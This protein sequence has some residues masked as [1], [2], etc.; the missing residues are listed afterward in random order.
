MSKQTKYHSIF[1][2]IR[3]N[4]EHHFQR[5]RSHPRGLLPETK[6]WIY[7]TTPLKIGLWLEGILF[8]RQNRPQNPKVKS[9]THLGNPHIYHLPLRDSKSKKQSKMIL[10]L[11]S[12]R[13]LINLPA[14]TTK[15]RL[16]Y[17]NLS[18][19][20]ANRPDTEGFWHFRIFH[21]TKR[22]K[23][24]LDFFFIFYLTISVQFHWTYRYKMEHD[25][26]RYVTPMSVL[27]FAQKCP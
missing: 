12:E 9:E 16:Q 24:F 4:Q 10:Y 20:F 2:K 23:T 15:N 26:W 8:F 22:V 7:P 6:F 25:R 14:D 18:S 5:H 3:L 13:Y 19:I 1:N 21:I 17:E 27:S 11:I